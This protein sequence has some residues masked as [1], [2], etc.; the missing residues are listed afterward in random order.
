ML[1]VIIIGAGVIGSMIA[2]ALSKY[3]LN[4]VVLEKEAALEQ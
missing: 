2:R 1:D 4:I 3:E